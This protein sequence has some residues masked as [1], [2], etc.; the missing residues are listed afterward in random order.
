MCTVTN[1]RLPPFHPRR[2]ATILTF[3]NS[4]QNHQSPKISCLSPFPFPPVDS[5]VAFCYYHE[6]E[7]T[8]EAF[9]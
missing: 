8:C 2:N 5:P 7:S 9:R 6:D 4:T 1:R 3:T